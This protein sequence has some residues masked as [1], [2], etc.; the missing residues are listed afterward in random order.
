[1]DIPLIEKYKIQAEVL[2]PLVKTLQAELGE[3]RANTLVREGIGQWARELGKTIGSM[4]NGS[5]AE[6]MAA[7]IPAFADGGALDLDM[8]EQTEDALD[9]NVTGCRYAKF[10]QELG[11]PELGFLL[12]CQAD[13]AMTEGVGSD[14]E[15]KRSQ[16]IMQGAA[17][18]DFRFRKK[19]S[20]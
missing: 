2:V 8:L 16:T 17:H 19:S 15:L 11:A 1:M 3:E 6:K 4:G 12:V 9:F 13:F 14:L 18:C 5:S 7:A 10:Y 20:G